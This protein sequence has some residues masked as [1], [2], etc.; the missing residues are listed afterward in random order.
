VQVLNPGSTPPPG[1]SP[2]PRCPP[3]ILQFRPRPQPQFSQIR[4][5][6]RPPVVPFKSLPNHPLPGPAPPTLA[7]P[8]A[9]L[10]AGPAIRPHT[11][12]TI[13]GGTK[14]VPPPSVIPC[15]PHFL[16]LSPSV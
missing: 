1:A 10:S 3:P 15:L 4:V 2:L 8:V 13:H 12:W 9:S 5:H 6:P 16:L 7:L 11:H 14:A